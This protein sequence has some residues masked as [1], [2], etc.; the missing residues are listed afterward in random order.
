[1]C[2][3]N[4]GNSHFINNIQNSGYWYLI[5]H[6]FFQFKCTRPFG[7]WVD[8]NDK[9]NSITNSDTQI[10]L[11]PD[12]PKGEGDRVANIKDKVRFLWMM[13]VRI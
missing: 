9:S 12:C 6:Y 7:K 10:K 11:N 5:F 4:S 13:Y 8:R 1:M 2:P 3:K